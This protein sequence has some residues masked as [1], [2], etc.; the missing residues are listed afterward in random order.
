MD[1]IGLL[2]GLGIGLVTFSLGVI[3]GRQ[4]RRGVNPGVW[5]DGCG[6]HKSYHDPVSG[7]CRASVKRRT[8]R[9]FDEYGY[10]RTYVPSECRC[11]HFVD[12]AGA[13][14]AEKG[15]P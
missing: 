3:L 7:K 12:A 11:M 13:S 2:L 9:M 10:F 8:V 6:D 15:T 1:V 4:R 14:T 5:C